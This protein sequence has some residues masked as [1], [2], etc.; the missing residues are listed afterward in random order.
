MQTI[1]VHAAAAAGRVDG[2]SVPPIFQAATFLYQGEDGYNSV[3]YTRCNNNPTQVA[4]GRQLAALEGAE[5]ALPLASGMA[6]ISSTLMHLLGPGSHLLIPETCYG[7]TH[8]LV[9]TLLKGWGV[10]ASPVAPD[11]GPEDWEK[12][13][14]PGKTRVFYMEAMTNP[15]VQV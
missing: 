3:R 5:A 6:A 7:G 11:S 8:D 14:Q 4:L 15:L 10:T 1:A 2:A 9:F 12:L 13:L